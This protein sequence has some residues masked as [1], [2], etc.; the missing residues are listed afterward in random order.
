M[1]VPCMLSWISGTFVSDGP[2][3]SE[4]EVSLAGLDI[5]EVEKV[6]SV[7]QRDLEERQFIVNP[8]PSSS[9]L[10]K[11]DSLREIVLKNV[12]IVSECYDEDEDAGY[13]EYNGSYDTEYEDYGSDIVINSLGHYE[14]FE[15]VDLSYTDCNEDEVED[16]SETEINAEEIESFLNEITEEERSH[17]IDVM[18]RDLELEIHRHEKIR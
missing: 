1:F 14:R 16:I 13:S 18:C 10:E 17:I 2:S 8:P 9:S 15:S 7:V 6:L 3:L 11:K 12:P 5:E 4:I